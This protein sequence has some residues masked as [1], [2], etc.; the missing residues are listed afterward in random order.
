M[1]D[2]AGSKLT[3]DEKKTL[4]RGCIGITAL[5]VDG[6]GN[7]PLD[8]AYSTFEKAKSAADAMNA[9][10][11]GMKGAK[12][13]VGVPKPPPGTRAIIFAQLFW[14]NQ[15]I[16]PADRTTPDPKAFLPDK[17]G[18]VEMSTYHY[19]A[20]PGYVNFDYGFWDAPTESFWHANHRQPGMKVYQSTRAK[21]AKGYID[22]DRIV[23]GVAVAHNYDPKKAA[24]SEALKG[25][26]SKP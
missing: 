4:A 6:S 18:R 14:S 19:R 24:V 25:A 3:D 22:F 8:L 21:F 13:P 10:I 12:L 16:D 1:G 15:A 26:A 20:R 17:E 23:Y 7:P 2:G 9:V 5:N 11:D